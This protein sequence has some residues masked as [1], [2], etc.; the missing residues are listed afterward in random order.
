MAVY[1]GETG[2][3]EIRRD[4]NEQALTT[5]LDP[6]DVNVTKKR[7]S[8]DFAEG[9]LITGDQVDIA[10]V[11][12][13]D[14][15]LVDGH[16]NQPDWRG[17]IY[18]DDAGGIR[19][20]DSFEESI[21]G[22]LGTAL[23]LE[24]PT[25]TK[26]IA[27]RTRSL[28][29]NCLASVKDYELTTSRDQIDTTVLGQE[30][31]NQYEAGLISGQGTLSCLWAYEALCEDGATRVE[32]ASYL[33]RLVLRLQQG[34]DFL[35]RFFIHWGGSTDPSSVWYEAECIITNV[36]VTVSP[37]QLID[38]RIQF[39]T[40]GPIVLRSG[41]PEA[42]LLQESGDL[43]LQEDGESGILLEDPN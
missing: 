40:S 37:A 10:T 6:N 35:G 43:I 1:L 4:A 30:H 18:L 25:A 7:F 42:Y 31:R 20:Y 5:S 3:V 11:D 14:L 21:T 17:F 38:T 22:E 33:A 15:I 36:A 12:K 13:S 39:V 32:F 16:D 34:A 24:T 8:V 23:A 2:F 41:I 28:Q 26:D 19:L 27:I 9:A 29:Y